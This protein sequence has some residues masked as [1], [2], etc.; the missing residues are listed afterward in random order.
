MGTG[1]DSPSL[2]T[3]TSHSVQDLDLLILSSDGLF[4]NIPSLMIQEILQ[5]NVKGYLGG[6]AEDLALEALKNSRNETYKSPFQENAH[7]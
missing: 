7:K 5:K 6:L 2:S 3:S 4:D 1:G